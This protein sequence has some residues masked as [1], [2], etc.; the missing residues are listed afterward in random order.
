M[1]HTQPKFD[2]WHANIDLK[3][4]V[5]IL[6]GLTQLAEYIEK[7]AE[8]HG[9]SDRFVQEQASDTLKTFEALDA[10]DLTFTQSWVAKLREILKEENNNG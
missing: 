9:K 1:T 10:T 3:T 2:F 6:T 4:R 7:Q 8:I 5:T